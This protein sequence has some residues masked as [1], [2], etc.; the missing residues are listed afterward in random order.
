MDAEVNRS[1][2]TIFV[3]GVSAIVSLTTLQI[4]SPINHLDIWT[5]MEE[6]Y[7]D[8]EKLSVTHLVASSSISSSKIKWRFFLKTRSLR[9]LS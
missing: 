3:K 4:P 9:S 7:K 5:A 8:E 1:T 6:Q 2:S